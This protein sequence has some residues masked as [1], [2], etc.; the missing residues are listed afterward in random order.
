MSSRILVVGDMHVGSVDSLMPPIVSLHPDHPSR[1]MEIEQNETQ[2]F[3]Y[4]K[5]EHMCDM[6]HFD[7]CFCMGDL[8]EGTN[9]KEDGMGTWTNERDTQIN[10]AID[11]LNMIDTDEFIGVQGS[12][13]HVENNTSADNDVLTALGGQHNVEGC[14]TVDGLR[15]HLRHVTGYSSIP[16]GRSSS[17]SKDMMN[18]QLQSESYGNVDIH[19]RAH[20]HYYHGVSWENSE[21]YISPCWKAR[22]DFL[23]SNK[24][25]GSDI[26]FLII[27]VDGS[28]LNDC[29]VKNYK[30]KVPKR[31]N[32]FEFE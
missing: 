26:G 24:I 31:L 17:L 5:W 7:H 21:A 18:T 16:T 29:K 6:G 4:S 14:K 12:R 2:E 9:Y 32:V 23:K 15:F 25:G 8:I 30:W 22:D 27:D 11:L 20:T 19:L 13:Y 10:T 1:T 3:M 28:D